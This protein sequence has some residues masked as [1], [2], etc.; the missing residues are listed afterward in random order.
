MAPLEVKICGLTSTADAQAA[1]KAGADWLG[2]NLFP[3]SPRCVDCPTALR[4]IEATPGCRHA[5]V[6]VRPSSAELEA[7]L[8]LPFTAVQLHQVE[9]LAA[10]AWPLLR[11]SG[12]P[13]ILAAGVGDAGDWRHLLELQRRAEAEL[14]RPVHRLLVDAKVAGQHGGTGQVAPWRLLAELRRAEPLWLAGGLKPTNVA[15]A[16]RLVQPVGVDVASGVESSPGRKD[17]EK[18]QTFVTAVRA[19]ASPRN[20]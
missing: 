9:D 16:I 13:L 17:F 7:T 15:E 4:I 14:A 19:T 5:A 12:L 1:Q 18:M 10:D 20:V 3:G 8:R 6:L 11:A 2:L